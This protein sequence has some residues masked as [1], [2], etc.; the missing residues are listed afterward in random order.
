MRYVVGNRWL[1]NTFG[2]THLNKESGPITL[3]IQRVALDYVVS[4]EPHKHMAN[5]SQSCNYMCHLRDISR[6]PDS[7]KQ[8]AQPV[9]DPLDAVYLLR[10]DS[11]HNIDSDASG[12]NR[13]NDYV[14]LI[15]DGLTSPPR[16]YNAQNL[17]YII[18]LFACLTKARAL[19]A[20]MLVD[21]DKLWGV[22]NTEQFMLCH[23]TRNPSYD[24]NC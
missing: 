6:T 8:D 10:R 12:E 15:R 18:S 13:R 1:G 11:C 2:H 16:D 5:Q 22:M 4:R 3:E 19:M 9:Y 24:F 7:V 21:V 20:Y 14:T 17:P 23:T